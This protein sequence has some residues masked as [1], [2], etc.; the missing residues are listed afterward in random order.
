MRSYCSTLAQFPRAKPSHKYEYDLVVFS[1]SLS[2]FIF[3]LLPFFRLICAQYKCHVSTRTSDR[4]RESKRQRWRR[5]C[6]VPESVNHKWNGGEKQ[7]KTHSHPRIN[8]IDGNEV[9]IDWKRAKKIR[10]MMMNQSIVSRQQSTHSRF[11]ELKSH[12]M[13]T[14]SYLS[15]IC[16]TFDIHMRSNG[17][18]SERACANANAF[19]EL[20]FHFSCIR[21]VMS[22]RLIISFADDSE[23]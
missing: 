7:K 16:P 11:I 12:R 2:V 9:K 21:N 6:V 15:N 3:L 14:V 22:W 5:N 13:F 10:E 18:Y 8:R 4:L 17:T 20:V 1:L 23:K 19:S